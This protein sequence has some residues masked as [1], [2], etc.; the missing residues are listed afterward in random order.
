MKPQNYTLM[1]AWGKKW[2]LLFFRARNGLGLGVAARL[3]TEPGLG[4]A[5]GVAGVPGP[6]APVPSGRPK[7]RPKSPI[8]GTPL[9]SWGPRGSS[10]RRRQGSV[11]TRKRTFQNL[12]F[13]SS[14]ESAAASRGQKAKAHGRAPKL[15]PVAARGT[16][17][18][19][20]GGGQSLPACSFLSPLLPSL[21]SF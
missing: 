1:T 2:G 14:G 3:A 17:G 11:Q 5:A 16:S 8:P 4:V 7:P 10:G 19:N 21:P 12:A 20:V 13:P 6:S 15:P 9:E 18:E